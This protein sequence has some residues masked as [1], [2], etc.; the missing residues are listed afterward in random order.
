MTNFYQG[1]ARGPIDHEASSVINSI[2]NE[3]I[4]MGAAIVLIDPPGTE[5]L[6]RVENADAV[7]ELGY[8]IVVGGDVDGIY[9]DGSASTDDTTRAANAAGQGV[10]VVTQGRCPAKVT[11]DIPTGSKLAVSTTGTL[12]IAVTTQSVIAISL[13]DSLG[14]GDH[15]IAVDVQREGVVA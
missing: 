5:L 8:G 11:G 2:A 1:L 14:A 3:S 4:D 12:Q 7:T 10:V 13:Q 9:G 15:I 6:P